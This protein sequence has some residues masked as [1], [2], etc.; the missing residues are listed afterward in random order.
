MAPTQPCAKYQYIVTPAGPKILPV[1]DPAC[2]DEESPADYNAGGYLPVKVGDTFKSGRYRVIRKLGW[3]HFSTVWLVKDTQESRHSALKVVKSAGRYAETARDEIKLFSRVASFSPTHPG[4]SHIV[5][6]LDSFVNQGPEASHVCIVFEPLGE[7]LLALIERNK[8]KGVPRA[9]VKAI[10]R[11]ILL[12]LQYLHD[13]CDLVHTDIKPE[14]ISST[15]AGSSSIISTPPTSLSHSLGNVVSGFMGMAKMGGQSSNSHSAI[16]SEKD[17]RAEGLPVKC[18]NGKGKASIEDEL[19]DATSTS[20]KDHIKYGSWTDK[21]SLSSS[22]KSSLSGHGKSKLC[23]VQSSHHS[24]PRPSV[25]SSILWKDPGAAAPAPAVVVSAVVG[26]DGGEDIGNYFDFAS[27]N[28]AGTT[29]SESSSATATIAPPSRNSTPVEPTTKN[30]ASA[31]FSGTKKSIADDTLRSPTDATPVES[32]TPAHTIA[33][34][35][36]SLLTQTAPVRTPPSSV[37]I[38][39]NILG[40]SPPHHLS[41]HTHSHHIPCTSSDSQHDHNLRQTGMSNT[42]Y[43]N[44]QLTSTN[45]MSPSLLT[46]TPSTLPPSA[47]PPTPVDTPSILSLIPPPVT[48]SARPPTLPIQVPIPEVFELLTA[49]FLFDPHGQGELFTKDDDHMAQIIELLG[50][51]PLEVK[52]EG[53]YSRELFDHTG[54]LRY[55]HSLKPW[56]LKRVMKE[57]YLYGDADAQALS[58]FL[59]PMLAVDMKQRNRARDMLDHP[60]LMLSHDEELVDEW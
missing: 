28:F 60:W 35:N 5:S 48:T 14:N 21:I 45:P 33:K 27:S 43:A 34:S 30:K 57:K 40:L 26:A 47:P 37:T 54:T 6:F 12:G 19:E 42:A 56:P 23:Q 51:F 25:P 49:E 17:P 7:N 24:Q 1:E 22:Y 29:V 44:F 9:L 59:L 3:G 16:I 32:T 10:A 20:W 36:P 18:R 53:R 38:Q 31:L 46:A 58:D 2:K 41:G 11:Q 52:M 8:K 13:E 4:R 55:I 15:T 39:R 50:D